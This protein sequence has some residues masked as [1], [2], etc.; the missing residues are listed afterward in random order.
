MAIHIITDTSS[1]LPGNISKH[2]HIPVLPQIVNFGT[3]SYYDGININNALFM[4]MLKKSKELPKTSAPPLGLFIQEFDRLV[5]KGGTIFCIHPSADVSAT[6]DAATVA[7]QEFPGADI[8]IIDTRTIGSPLATLVQLAAELAEQGENADTIEATLK[9]MIPR[10]RIYFLVNSL[11]Y[12]RKGGRIGDATALLGSVLRMIP[13]LTLKD[14][15]VEQFEKVRTQK[16][17]IKRLSELVITQASQN[18][19][20]HI[21]IMHAE[22]PKLANTLSRMLCQAFHIKNIPISDLPPATV[23]H[24]GPGI[25]AAAFFTGED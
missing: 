1:G 19:D 10:S 16:R 17:A 13:I 24:G 7:A 23:A 6:I 14:G 20:A 5:P 12:L 11:E 18:N 9:Q 2:Y 22:V 4:K 15:H 3:N 8:R 21:S 25:L